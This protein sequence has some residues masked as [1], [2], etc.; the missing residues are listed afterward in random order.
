ML[1]LPVKT[2]QECG[3]TICGDEQSDPEL[4][5]YLG[6]TLTKQFGNNFHEY[7]TTDKPRMVLNK[8]ERRGYKVISQ[9]GTGQT[10]VWTLHKPLPLD[11]GPSQDEGS[12]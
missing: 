7:C 11:N 1:I 12:T 6:A 4:M 3:P 5:H 2:S 10:M 9:S 8:L